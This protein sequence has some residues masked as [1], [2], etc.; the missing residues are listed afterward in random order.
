MEIRKQRFKKSYSELKKFSTENDFWLQL[1]AGGLIYNSKKK[2]L[3][4]ELYFLRLETG[5]YRSLIHYENTVRKICVREEKTRLFS[6]GSIFNCE[7]KLVKWPEPK[8]KNYVIGSR[9]I[10]SNSRNKSSVPLSGL[11]KQINLLSGESGGFSKVFYYSF[12][13]KYSFAKTHYS[14]HVEVVVPSSLIGR[15]FHY[16][17]LDMI[18]LIVDNDFRVAIKRDAN[19]PA[20]V[21]YDG[22]K[23]SR[24][25]AE[26][27]G[28]YFFTSSYSYSE[29]K[30]GIDILQKSIDE[31]YSQLLNFAKQKQYDVMDIDFEIPFDF[32]FYVEVVG[33]FLTD[34]VFLAY[35][36]VKAYPYRADK[37][38]FSTKFTLMDINAAV[39]QPGSSG[40]KGD[41]SKKS[42][43]GKDDQNNSDDTTD[44]TEDAPVNKSLSTVQ[45]TMFTGGLFDD[46]PDVTVIEN[47]D[48]LRESI[49]RGVISVPHDG[50]SFFDDEYSVDP[51]GKPQ[52][53]ANASFIMEYSHFD[54]IRE[55][56]SLLNELDGINVTYLTID[57]SSDDVFSQVLLPTDDSGKKGILLTILIASIIH[58]EGRETVIV[59]A[60]PGLKIG[61][62]ENMDIPYAQ[63]NDAR[64]TSFVNFMRRRYRF[65]WSE[66]FFNER[67][68][69]D[70]S[71]K[72]TRSEAIKKNYRIK[73]LQPMKH[74]DSDDAETL[75]KNLKERIVAR[76][77]ED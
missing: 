54:V 69:E 45:L 49:A 67:V 12:T 46:A 33:Q 11:F 6:V 37:V 36:I 50:F 5:E 71:L 26:R 52:R 42:P 73:V 24:E 19:D 28:K 17:S 10:L 39:S 65:Q 29:Y 59:D 9:I 43:S 53:R 60:G 72:R 8:E 70:N 2:C 25:D 15:Y 56:L 57:Q 74:I 63:S 77:R 32:P 20:L 41:S 44:I 22:K 47:E 18:K 23:I 1:V 55:A 75:R 68:K 48:Q 40:G 21:L 51:N 76:I 34:D 58:K 16:L 3:E 4:R 7:G 62:Y 30:S 38:P 61:M 64:L 35:D 66:V 14:Q 27:L 31:L 13:P